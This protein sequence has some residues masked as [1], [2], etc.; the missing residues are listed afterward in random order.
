[1][2]LW[3]ARLTCCGLLTKVSHKCGCEMQFWL[4]EVV[5]LT[6]LFTDLLIL[7]HLVKGVKNSSTAPSEIPTSEIYIYIYAILRSGFQWQ[8]GFVSRCVQFSLKGRKTKN[9]KRNNV[10]L[11]PPWLWSMF[12]I[13][14]IYPCLVS[15]KVRKQNNN[16][17]SRAA[18]EWAGFIC[19][20]FG[21]NQ[22]S[23]SLLSVVAHNNGCEPLL[24]CQIFSSYSNH[25]LNCQP[26]A[27]FKLI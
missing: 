10:S 22:F 24:F 5:L 11:S 2:Y 26:F 15:G 8:I 27:F 25:Q 4:W 18:R 20:L 14:S 1:M 16:H 17:Y 9:Q 23:C 13:F 21:N 7:Y 6:H 19:Y 12:L 3:R